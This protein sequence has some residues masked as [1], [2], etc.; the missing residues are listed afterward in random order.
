MER[1]IDPRIDR[2]IPCQYE[3]HGKSLPGW[4]ADVSM[5]GACIVQEGTPPPVGASVKLTLLGD[6]QYC[7][8]GEVAHRAAEAHGSSERPS[9]GVQLTGGSG[10]TD[11]WTFLALSSVGF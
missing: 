11:Y 9:F 6:K 1:R 4:T 10:R 5:G 2:A 8:Q 3:W 7:L